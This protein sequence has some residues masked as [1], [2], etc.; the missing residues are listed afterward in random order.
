M[1][2]S[3][4][5]QLVLA[6]I[7]L[8]LIAFSFVNVNQ[9]DQRTDI[10]RQSLDEADDLLE[11]AKGTPHHIAAFGNYYDHRIAWTMTLYAEARQSIWQEIILWSGGSVLA[12]ILLSL[13]FIP[14]RDMPDY[15]SKGQKVTIIIAILFGLVGAGALLTVLA[16][17]RNDHFAGYLEGKASKMQREARSVAGVENPDLQPFILDSLAEDLDFLVEGNSDILGDLADLNWPISIASVLIAFSILMIVAQVES[18]NPVVSESTVKRG[19]GILLLVSLT[20]AIYGWLSRSP[21]Q[22][23]LLSE[24]ASVG[25]VDP[26]STP[27]PKPTPTPTNT[28]ENPLNDV[29]SL[30]T[31]DSY[32]LL[33]TTIETQGSRQSKSVIT[34]TAVTTPTFA[35]HLL[36]YQS[37]HDFYNKRDRD[38]VFPVGYFRENIGLA[39]YAWYRRGDK[40]D[41][42]WQFS[43]DPDQLAEVNKDY[44]FY[45]AKQDMTGDLIEGSVTLVGEEVLYGIDTH[46]YAIW[47]NYNNGDSLAFDLW[48]TNHLDLP[49]ILV[50]VSGQAS[51]FDAE[52]GDKRQV[53][54][55]AEVQKINQPLQIEQPVAASVAYVDETHD[56]N[57]LLDRPLEF[58]GYGLR[59]LYPEAWDVN[60]KAESCSATKCHFQVRTLSWD[61]VLSVAY[62]RRDQ[63]LTSSPQIVHTAAVQERIMATSA[64]FLKE[65]C[66]NG[67]EQTA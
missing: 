48:I 56:H 23:D 50:K 3:R 55:H 26:V 36:E 44:A 63:S 2:L 6:L 39:D 13:F 37:G 58:M 47:E 45:L 22:P 33:V 7:M 25:S 28:V 20:V 11:A 32:Q 34:F 57:A 41:K 4:L 35:Y 8:G 9:A 15:L 46:H 64:M 21:E 51:H 62:G 10:A 52:L 43:H 19:I 67:F 24:T 14:R 65:P 66:M 31:L 61:A 5:T 54:I 18:D 12:L 53:S 42:Y 1:R 29:V 60:L 59:L 16:D 17:D 40:P 30:D 27:K 49:K 38:A